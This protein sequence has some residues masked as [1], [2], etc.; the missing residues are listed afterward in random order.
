MGSVKVLRSKLRDL[1]VVDL[2]GNEWFLSASYWELCDYGVVQVWADKEVIAAFSAP[3]TVAWFDT[4]S[5]LDD[6]S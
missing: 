5:S 1:Y 4:L 2:G 6:D 3:Q